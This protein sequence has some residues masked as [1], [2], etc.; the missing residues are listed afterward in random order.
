MRI[1]RDH[2][3]SIGLAADDIRIDRAG[4][5]SACGLEHDEMCVCCGRCN[6]DTHES[7]TRPANGGAA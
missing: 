7:C 4:G 2:L 3:I 5:C 1:S 6:C